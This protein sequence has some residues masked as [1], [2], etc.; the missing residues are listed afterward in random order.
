MIIT[1]TNRFFKILAFIAVCLTS[2]SAFAD[3]ST[4]KAGDPAPKLKV[5]Q[6]LYGEPVAELQK[7]K[8]YLIEFWA[9][10]CAPCIASM[11]HL[12]KIH[13]KYAD[14]GLVIIAVAVWENNPEAARA[15]VKKQTDAG[16]LSFRFA[17][18]DLAEEARGHMAKNW[19]TAMGRSS[20]PSTILVDRTGKVVWA[21]SPVTID[22]NMLDSFTT[23]N[24]T[25]DDVEAAK[26]KMVADRA[27][28]GQTYAAIKELIRAGEF[29]EARIALAEAEKEIFANDALTP[30]LIRI[31]IG[32]A[33]NELDS[34]RSALAAMEA[35]SKIDHFRPQADANVANA[36]KGFICRPEAAKFAL[37]QADRALTRS[38]NSGFSIS[39]EGCRLHALAKMGRLDEV[40]TNHEALKKKYADDPDKLEFFAKL[41]EELK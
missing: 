39:I 38:P 22:E 40:H 5:G 27:L 10:W 32:A 15:F 23:G 9:S 19:L 30:D 4:L 35:N 7:D 3:E 13:Q 41:V 12:E 11:P 34:A 8:A 2:F 16:N 6:W 28:H 36:L 29:D 37:E 1:I 25:E 14:E 18:D 20:L 33:S 31:L 24:F 21:G 26:K 17:L